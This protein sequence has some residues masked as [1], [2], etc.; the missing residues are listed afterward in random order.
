MT[1]FMLLFYLFMMPL[2]SDLIEKVVQSDKPLLNQN[3]KSL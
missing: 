3:K 2:G 1:I